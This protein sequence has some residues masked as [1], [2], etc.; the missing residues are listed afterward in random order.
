MSKQFDDSNSGSAWRSENKRFENAADWS[1]T[2][3]VDG[4]AYYIDIWDKVVQNQ[5]SDRF[6]EEFKSIRVKKKGA[7]NGSKPAGR[8]PTSAADDR[9]PWE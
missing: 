7:T 8:K 9:A 6:G 2:I 1:G 4:V 5:S 3:N